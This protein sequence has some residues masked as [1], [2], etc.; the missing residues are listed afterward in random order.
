MPKAYEYDE[1]ES[2]KTERTYQ[3]PEIIQQRV[4]FMDAL[5]LQAGECA[6]DVGCGPGLLNFEMALAVGDNGHVIGFD[7]S[8]AI[9]R[10]LYSAIKL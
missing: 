4:A 2:R 3:S 1:A 5:N 7:N 10:F 6:I 9:N 8:D